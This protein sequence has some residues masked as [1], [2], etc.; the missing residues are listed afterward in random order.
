MRGFLPERHSA[1]NRSQTA[2]ISRRVATEVR[3][4]RAIT[5]GSVVS[6]QLSVGSRQLVRRFIFRP[7]IVTAERCSKP[8][9]AQLRFTTKHSALGELV[10]PDRADQSQ[11]AL[12]LAFAATEHLG[13]FP[14]RM[15]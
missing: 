13:H 7:H 14:I 6:G 3:A 11:L 15:T 1:S 9:T 5:E 4:S 8:D 10:F 2:S 12:D